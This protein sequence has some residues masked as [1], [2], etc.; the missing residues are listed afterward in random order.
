[1]VNIGKPVIR[2]LSYNR[3]LVYTQGIRL[4]NQQWGDEHGLG[5]MEMG[6]DK[7]EIIKG[8]SSMLYG[9]DA[10]GGV[11]HLIEERPA[12]PEK[13]QG[14]YNLKLFS[15]TQGYNTNLGFKGASNKLRYGIRAGLQSHAD[16]KMGNG[17]RVTNSRFSDAGVKANLGLNYN[18]MITNFNYQFIG[19]EVGIPEEVALQSTSRKEMSPYQ[20]LDSHLFSNQTSFFINNSRLKANLGYSR[21]QRKEFEEDAP[22]ENGPALDMQLSTFSYDIKWYLPSNEKSTFILGIQ[23]LSQQNSNSGE[24][25]LIPDAEVNDFGGLV[26]GKY[27]LSDFSIQ[28]GL[29]F[30][31]RHIQTNQIGELG[32]QGFVPSIDRNFTSLNGA[33]GATYQHKEEWLLRANFATGFR[34][35]N[36]AELASNGPHEGTNRYE[37]CNPDLQNER[38]YEVDLGAEWQTKHISFVLTGFYNYI[39]DYIF[40]TPTNSFIEGEQVYNFIQDDANLKGFESALHIHPHPLDW[41]HFESGFSLVNAQRTDGEEL[42]LIPAYKLNNVIRAEFNHWENVSNAFFQVSIKTAFRQSRISEFETITP[43]YTLVNIGIGSQL[44][45][46]NQIADWNLTINNLLDHNYYDHLSRL[47]VNGINNIGR[48]TSLGLKVPFGIK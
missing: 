36:L 28:T 26:L 48:N 42:P 44:K 23:G 43:G 20:A 13:I 27:S 14:D 40:L 46:G 9:S 21:N 24:E 45:I 16:Y 5:L 18:W 10:M 3:V 6:I 32:E 37:I 19:S 8:P 25:V 33:L 47:K 15:N 1:G 30:D 41:L 7:V 11:L 2:G 31:R 39:S 35:P 34:A 17:N 4:E 12:A 29:R 38:N 22:P